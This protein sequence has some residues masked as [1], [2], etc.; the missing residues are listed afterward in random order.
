[1]EQQN[2]QAGV[3]I[4]GS[5]PLAVVMISLNEGHN[6]RDTL[7]NLKGFAQEVFLVDSYSVDDTIDIALEYGI[8]VVQRKFSGFGDQWNFALRE[9]PISAAWTM[10][11]D[12][13]ER[14]DDCLK[15]SISSLV[16]NANANGIVVNRKLWFMGRALPIVQPI[17]RLWKTG[18]C[19]FT[20]VAVNEHPLV[21]GPLVTAKGELKHFDSPDL[22]HW[23]AKQNRY[24]TMEA[25]W[26]FQ[27]K[28]LA[29]SPK[30]FG[31][32][33]QRRMWLKKHFWKVP[34]R[35]IALFLYNYLIQGAWR[36]GRAGYIW[37]RLRSDV[38]RLWEYKYAEISLNG[39]MPVQVPSQAGLPDPRIE[40]K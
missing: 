29:A 20:D 3:W 38:Y 39:Q 32:S 31:N 22:E 30:L 1:M 14:L 35:Y 26:Q 17:L 24:T 36:A 12:P 11:L 15:A 23:L 27:G 37:A 7:E 33:L 19:Q 9:L 5:A 6:L 40:Q 18:V 28:N 2:Q 25:I 13:D 16:S 34:G 21:A 4:P 10:K 8:H